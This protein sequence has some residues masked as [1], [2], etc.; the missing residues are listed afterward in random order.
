MA[1]ESIIK[2]RVEVNDAN[3]KIA[4]LER[5][6]E[7]LEKTTKRAQRSANLLGNALKAIPFIGVADGVRRF[8]KGFNEADKARA[9]VKTLGVDVQELQKRLLQVSERSGGLAS[10]TQLLAA[11]YDVASA[12]FSDAG[13]NA[14]ILEA[15]LKG[16]VGGLSD[17]NT[18]SDAAT[19]VLNAYGLE[20][21]KVDKIVDGF[22]QTQNDG[23]IVVGQYAT[24]IGRLAP[25]AAAAGVSIDE[26]NAAIST[27]TAQGVPIE[28]TFAGL[29]QAIASVLKPSS[30]ATKLAEGLGLE[31]NGAALKA[32][33]FGGFME[34]VREK[35]G[36]S[37]EAMTLLFG[38]VE[39]VGAVLPLTNDGLVRFNKNLDNQRTKTG[40]AAAATEDL[41]GTVTS[42]ITKMI[43]SIGNLAR[44]LDEVLGPTVGALVKGINFIIKQATNGIRV[45]SQFFSLN[46]NTE[47][48][49]QAILSGDIDRGNVFRALP[50][51]DQLI[52]EERRKELQRQAGFDKPL[53]GDT[54]KFTE[55]LSKEPGLQALLGKT[56]TPVI[57]PEQPPEGL[58]VDPRIQSIIDSLRPGSDGTTEGGA[59]TKKAEKTPIELQREELERMIPL[60]DRRLV[61]SRAAN[62]AERKQ[63]EQNLQ[64]AEFLE[65]TNLLSEEERR[66]GL[67]KIVNTYAQIDAQEQLNRDKEAAAKL[68][69]E[70]DRRQKAAAD[71]ILQRYRMIGDVIRNGLVDGLQ[72]AVMGTKT[73]AEVAL[74]TL[75]NLANTLLKTGLNMAL[76]SLGGGNPASIFTKLFGGERANGGPVTGGKSYLVGERG[77][78]LFSPGRSGRITPNNALMGG[79]SIVVNVDASGSAVEG[80]GTQAKQLGNVIGVAVRQELL[81]QKRPGGLL[82]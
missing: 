31:F 4:Q 20:A 60:L 70:N 7:G 53:G 34:E 62:E 76:S 11:A 33:G 41:G 49:R 56:K 23:K 45:L 16:A 13:A 35:T 73:L 57:L 48:A 54:K 79:G 26:V 10:Q 21:A 74:N 42:E 30:Q 58:G 29:R 51:I 80:E 25:I 65:K 8:F 55:L 61:L 52:G 68:Q 69:D 22:I 64:I 27:V 36:G 50:G 44:A 43:N 19:S 28:S 9:A 1:V 38:S 63:I 18:V 15:S 82:A 2:L 32:K 3:R 59:R 17:L 5:S 47:I 75:N 67:D 24:Q 6:I 14:K 77:P 37:T 40:Q 66:R 72:A 81:K 12:G 46:K 78:E 39:A 71:A